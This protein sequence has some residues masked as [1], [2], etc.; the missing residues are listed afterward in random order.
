MTFIVGIINLIVTVAAVFGMAAL[1]FRGREELSVK[2]CIAC[3]GMVAVWCSS[4]ILISMSYND[5]QFVASYVYGSLGIC[6]IGV[7]WLWFAILYC[8]KKLDKKLI[9]LTAVIPTF[10]FLAVA[11]NPLHHMYHKIISLEKMENGI[12]FYTNFITIYIYAVIGAILLFKGVTIKGI[13]SRGE[14]DSKNQSISRMLIVM[15]VLAPTAISIYNILEGESIKSDT[16][17]IGFAFSMIFIM[18]ATFKYQFL[19]L[20][21]ELVI[22]NEKL[23]I[24]TERNRIAQQVHDTVGHTLTMIQSY[25]KL[26]EVSLKKDNAICHR[27]VRPEVISFCTPVPCII[28]MRRSAKT[29]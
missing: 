29:A 28:L 10:H 21:K 20:R 24:E 27:I 19:D 16:N 1:F 7:C 14:Q 15:S 4:Q 11:T 13:R 12:L 22:T 26:A 17:S 2:M 23:L 9:T 18:M 6:F 25:M 3:H 8:G 5:R